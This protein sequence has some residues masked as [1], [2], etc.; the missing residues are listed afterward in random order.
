MPELAGIIGQT[1]LQV[2]S[3][4]GNLGRSLYRVRRTVSTGAPEL[5]EWDGKLCRMPEP[6]RNA[7]L[8]HMKSA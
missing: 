3:L 7:V 8:K 2:R 1:P 4:R 6:V 5:W